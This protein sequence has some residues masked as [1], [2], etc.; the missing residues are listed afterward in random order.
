MAI[1][2]RADPIRAGS[3]LCFFARDAAL[4]ASCCLVR[5]WTWAYFR[6]SRPQDSHSTG[7]V[8][9]WPHLGQVIWVGMENSINRDGF[10]ERQKPES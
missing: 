9:S 4:A 3:L 5:S 7:L 10:V 6:K 2:N 8:C 1:S